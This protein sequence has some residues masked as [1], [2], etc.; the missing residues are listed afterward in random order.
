MSAAAD[1]ADAAPDVQPALSVVKPELD[2]ALMNMI[3]II[4]KQQNGAVTHFRMKRDAPFKKVNPRTQSASSYP[5]PH[6]GAGEHSARHMRRCARAALRQCICI[7]PARPPPPQLMDI[8]CSRQSLDLRT[9]KFLWDGHTLR[10]ESTPTELG[11]CFL[12]ASAK[13]T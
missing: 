13:R 3:N 7:K 9:V 5:P 8:F 10:P 11:T 2:P 6:P 4:V 1:A 12:G